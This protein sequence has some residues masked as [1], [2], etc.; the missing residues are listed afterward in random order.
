MSEDYEDPEPASLDDAQLQARLASIYRVCD[1]AWSLAR[2]VLEFRPEHLPDPWTQDLAGVWRLIRRLLNHA[3]LEDLDFTLVDTRTG[4]GGFDAQIWGQLYFEHRAADGPA[5]CVGH[6]GDA[7]AML[8][9]AT[10]AVS[11]AW[12]FERRARGPVGS[13]YREHAID[14]STVPM[15]DEIDAALAA[16]VLGFGHVL[17]TASYD[18]RAS[19]TS[20]GAWQQSAWTTNNFGLPVELAVRAFAVW[21]VLSEREEAEVER[22]RGEFPVTQ[23]KFLD[24]HYAELRHLRAQWLEALGLEGLAPQPRA[25]YTLA[26]IE[27]DPE[28]AAQLESYESERREQLRAFNRGRPLV[29]VRT[30][31]RGFMT[32]AGALTGV[33]ASVGTGLA[34]PILA[35]TALGY[36]AAQPML[37]LRCS[38]PECEAKVSAETKECPRCGGFFVGTV[39]RASQ[40]LAAIEAWEESQRGVPTLPELDRAD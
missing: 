14:F 29:R 8:G 26:P 3:G 37:S 4:D 2:P 15:P 38:D 27:L 34:W 10:L 33:F 31:P 23:R 1:P 36:L 25:D 12:L 28:F 18:P 11:W 20:T 22:L 39:D 24:P 35:G 13:A 9:P 19:G 32:A 30:R 7:R 17:A 6:I 21:L 40:R 16:V 5:F